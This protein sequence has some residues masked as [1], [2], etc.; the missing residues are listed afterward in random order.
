M[1]RVSSNNL[2]GTVEL[3]ILRTLHRISPAHGLRIAEEVHRLSG[4]LLQLEEG[5][6][7]P[8]LHRLQ[9]AGFIRGEWKISEKRRR[10]RFY[11]LT[12]AGKRALESEMAGWMVHTDAVRRV[13]GL[14]WTDM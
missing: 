3:L 4:E 13:L 5:A 12:A 8:A 2:Y 9:R 10:A 11:A 1:T 14:A 7:Y 6:L